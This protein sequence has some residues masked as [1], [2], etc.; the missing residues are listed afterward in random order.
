MPK[1]PMA[2]KA[3]SNPLPNPE[4]LHEAGAPA[5]EQP[6]QRYQLQKVVKPTLWQRI[7]YGANAS[8]VVNQQASQRA[9]TQSVPVTE[10]LSEVREGVLAEM[11][12]M[13]RTRGGVSGSPFANVVLPQQARASAAATLPAKR[14]S[15]GWLVWVALIALFAWLLLQVVQ[16]RSAP[17]VPQPAATFE[18]PEALQEPS[19][20]G[21]PSLADQPL[22]P[23]TVAAP[24]ID[25]L[26]AP[27]ETLRGAT[28][29]KL[30][31]AKAMSSAPVVNS[32]NQL[33]FAATLANGGAQALRNVQ[34]ALEVD[35]YARVP[36]LR[37]V[38][39]V[40]EIPGND[41][42]SQRFV[43]DLL[44]GQPERLVATVPL[45][46]LVVRLIP[47]QAER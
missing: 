5:V 37:R 13:A 12:T 22:N 35:D 47:L 17:L 29:G 23:P 38:L 1:Q 16:W 33:V 39:N 41:T 14:N 32:P 44:P 46:A 42:H 8:K 34:L 18:M 21:R 7:W 4:G 25:L 6:M 43:L 28:L 27:T 11:Q 30:V 26:A 10:S 9:A 31:Q 36:L 20:E 45:R 15:W 24:T 2:M 3:K 40:A 19:L